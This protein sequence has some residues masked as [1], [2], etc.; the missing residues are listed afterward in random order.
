MTISFAIVLCLFAQLLGL[1]VQ[2]T[3]PLTNVP[4]SLYIQD[5][6][7]CLEGATININTARLEDV[8]ASQFQQSKMAVNIS[9]QHGQIFL[10]LRTGLFFVYGNIIGPDSRY[11]LIGRLSDVQRSLSQIKYLANP[12]YYGVDVLQLTAVDMHMQ[13]KPNSAPGESELAL[14]PDHA[15]VSAS[16]EITVLAVND[17]PVITTSTRFLTCDQQQVEPDGTPAISTASFS[18]TL[19]DVDMLTEA[20][21]QDTVFQLSIKATYGKLT[22]QSAQCERLTYNCLLTGNL[23]VLNAAMS[24]VKYTPDAAYNKFNGPERIGT[25][26]SFLLLWRFAEFCNPFFCVSSIVFFMQSWC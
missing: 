13:P 4:P 12:D 11:E 1:A 15:P 18:A 17:A 9:V 22:L 20:Q 16:T 6:V 7:E 3:T 19:S 8:D 24:S 10:P 23:A 26:P 21:E 25:N 14:H 2:A 5:K